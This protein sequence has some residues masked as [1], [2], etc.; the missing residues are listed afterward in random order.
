[1]KKLIVVTASV[2]IGT[3]ISASAAQADQTKISNFDFFDC[4]KNN[5]CVSESCKIGDYIKDY[6]CDSENIKFPL[7]DF[8]HC[9]KFPQI[10]L[11]DI[12][13]K[14]EKPDTPETPEKPEL[15]ET[16]ETPDV[17]DEPEIPNEPETPDNPEIP[18]KP[19]NDGEVD[20]E[21]NETAGTYAEQI[22]SLVNKYRAQSGLKALTLDKNLSAAAGIRAKEIVSSFSHT[23]PNGSSCFTALSELGISYNGA[24]ENIAYGQ[25]SAQEVMTAWMNSQGHRENIMSSSFTKLGV[26]VYSS[27]GTL[28]WAQFFTY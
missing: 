21:E 7:L 6:L 19:E 1:M 12:F 10:S 4:V 20:K 17:P 18:E 13:D 22:L 25:E 24:G 3:S 9:D 5:S 8:L 2:I 23:R 26:G 27:G 11:P 16:P 28:Y 14:P 15:P